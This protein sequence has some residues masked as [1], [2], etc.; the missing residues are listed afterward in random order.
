V[1]SIGGV[2]A[3]DPG[4]R[5]V[6]CLDHLYGSN[7][8]VEKLGPVV[9]AGRWPSASGSYWHQAR[10]QGRLRTKEYGPY[11]HI[12]AGCYFDFDRQLPDGTRY[13]DHTIQVVLQ[14]LVREGLLQ[15]DKQAG[16]PLLSG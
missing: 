11:T 1:I 15:A 16:A 7:D 8:Y 3:S 6:R 10:V 5:S 2:M 12:G 4:L 9:F 13:G 14:V